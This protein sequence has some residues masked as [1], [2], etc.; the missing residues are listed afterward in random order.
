MMIEKL[1]NELKK[2]EGI[3]PHVYL[4]SEGYYTCGVGHLITH[5]DAEYGWPEDAEVSEERIEELLEQ[6]LKICITDARAVFPNFDEL[7]EDAKMT[8]CNM[9][10]QLGRTKFSKFKKFK[11]ALLKE[12]FH[13]AANQI[14]DSLYAK[15]TPARANRQA[16]RIKSLAVAASS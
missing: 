15:Q 4:C 3:I 16:D 1:K 7:H 6:D 5:N 13:E 14:L 2:D 10:F 8:V 12:D 9:T 11:E